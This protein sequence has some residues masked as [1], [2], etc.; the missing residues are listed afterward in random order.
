MAKQTVSD[1]AAR[2]RC[3]VVVSTYND[4]DLVCD[5]I[6]SLLAQREQ[7]I[8]IIV[9]DDGSQDGTAERLATYAD[10]PRVLVLSLADNQGVPGARNLGIKA[11][12]G[13]IIAFMDA[14]ATAPNDW[15]K[16]LLRPFDS[17]R[18]G[19]V[20]GPDQA[21]PEDNLFAQ[22][23]DFTLRS[24]IATGRLRRKTRLAR[25]SPG[26]CNMAVRASIFDEVG[27]LDE[28]LGRRGEEKE[29]IQRIRRRG[30]AILYVPEAL[31]WHRRRPSIRSF[32]KQTYLSGR[33]RV[34]ILRLVPDA[35]EPAHLF[36]A[37]AS[38]I[39]T[40]ALIGALLHPGGPLWAAPL[41]LYGALMLG[42]GLIAGLRLR[43]LRAVC[44]T[45]LTSAIVH[46]GYGLGFWARLLEVG[47]SVA[48]RRFKPSS[49]WSL[50]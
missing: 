30:Y 19:C 6:D 38:L 3:S 48:M 22:C 12:R 50:L 36:P 29:L 32:W 39:L 41:A 34:D 8:E 44:Y 24:L 26:G 28:R 45:A 2:L 49:K 25:Y 27:L 9:V 15:L 4:G 35:L 17:D 5:A 42:N 11:A 43:S 14:D 33:A 1:P 21:P 18:V 37:V 23:V 13:E 47:F 16:S 46:I 7:R 40:V 31:I 10:N 20:G